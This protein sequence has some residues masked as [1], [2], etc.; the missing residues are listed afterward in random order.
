MLQA[1]GLRF[2]YPWLLQAGCKLYVAYSKFYARGVTHA[3]NDR[4]LGIRFA[5][6]HL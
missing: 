6:V 4:E 1:P 5:V 3:E 2:H